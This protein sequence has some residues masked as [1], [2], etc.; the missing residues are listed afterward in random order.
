MKL[1][2]KFWQKMC[3]QSQLWKELSLKQ[4]VWWLYVFINPKYC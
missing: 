1:I 3:L 4:S 2:E